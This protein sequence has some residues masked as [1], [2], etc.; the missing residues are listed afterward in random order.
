MKVLMLAGSLDSYRDGPDGFII[1]WVK[2]L[3]AKVDQLTVLTYHYNPQEKLPANT[4]VYVITGHNLLTR[5]FNLFSKTLQL[6][7]N[8]DVIFAHILEIFGIAAGIIGKIT[9]K[10]S[11]FWYAQGYDLSNNFGAKI[12]FFFVDKIFTSTPQVISHYVKIGGPW[13]RKKVAAM[14]H[15]LFLPHY[16]LGFRISWPKNNSKPVKILYAGR[17]SPIKGVSVLEEA[18][19][20]LISKKQN[21]DLE[22]IKSF[23]YSQNAKV[24]KSTNIFVMPTLSRVPDK[25]FME[26]LICGVVAIGSDVA[27]S[28]MKDK[29]PQLI[30]KTGDSQDL[31]KKISWII[32]N[33]P[34]ARQITIKAQNYVKEN[35]D[36]D[37]LMDKIAYAF[38]KR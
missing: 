9:G 24:L 30:F 20:I 11:F 27:Y 19:K 14:G 3:A 21:V 17:V 5:N 10:K 12:A 36:L 16:E 7:K 18:V 37:K 33:Y 38:A 2:V 25:I 15:G 1:D 29:F 8:S 35:F 22:I 4:K 13:V 26:A 32:N 23:P 31:A 28:F 34:D 6:A